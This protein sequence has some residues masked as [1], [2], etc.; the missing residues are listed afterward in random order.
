MTGMPLEGSGFG[1]GVKFLFSGRHFEVAQ[2]MER[3]MMSSARWLC[4]DLFLH[5]LCVPL[6]AIGQVGQNV[7][8]LIHLL[9]ID[10]RIS[11]ENPY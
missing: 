8:T 3:T 1:M 2:E 10:V 9:P 6:L 4:K 5:D 11:A 7:L